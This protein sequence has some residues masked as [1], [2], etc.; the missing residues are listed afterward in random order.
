M[1]RNAHEMSRA[2]ENPLLLKKLYIQVPHDSAVPAVPQCIPQRTEHRYS[3]QYLCMHVNSSISHRR[4]RVA[5]AQMFIDGLYHNV[6]YPYK[7]ILLCSK[8]ESTSQMNHES[9]MLSE[10]SHSQKTVSARFLSNVI[11]R[12]G[13]FI[14]TECKLVAARAAGGRMWSDCLIGTGFPLGVM[15]IFWN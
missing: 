5:T 12:R 2:M 4:Q 6:V 8:K 14:K 15:K 1:Q 13:K 3:N 10:R 9:V 11:S 7:G